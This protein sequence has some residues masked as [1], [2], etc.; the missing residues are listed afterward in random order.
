M[1]SYRLFQLSQTFRRVS[2][3]L[4][5]QDSIV[6]VPTQM[7]NQLSF[8]RGLHRLLGTGYKVWGGGGG[9][10]G[11]VVGPKLLGKPFCAPFQ[12]GS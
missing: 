9:Q 11:K 5:W 4:Y 7:W 6:P 12:R 10:N 2:C 3:N 8:H 1:S